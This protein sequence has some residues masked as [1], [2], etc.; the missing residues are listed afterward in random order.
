[1]EEYRHYLL[2]HNLTLQIYWG[3]IHDLLDCTLQLDKTFLSLINPLNE[4]LHSPIT[5]EWNWNPQSLSPS[6]HTLEV[7]V[8][9]N[10]G[11]VKRSWNERL[12]FDL[13]TVSYIQIPKQMEEN[14]K[15]LQFKQ[16]LRCVYGQVLVLILFL[17]F[18]YQSNKNSKERPYQWTRLRL[19]YS[20]GLLHLYVLGMLSLFC[21]I[22][23]CG[24]IQSEVFIAFQWGSF[25]WKDSGGWEYAHWRD[26]T[27]WAWY[28]CLLCI[29]PMFAYCMCHVKRPAFKTTYK[30]ILFRL[31]EWISSCIPVVT[32]C[33]L[34]ILL[35]LNVPLNVFL[36]SF[37]FTWLPLIIVVF[38]FKMCDQ[39]EFVPLIPDD[40]LI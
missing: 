2:Q 11:E 37:N 29:L 32:I 6:I 38:S 21:G 22:Y 8:V 34:W 7:T 20:Y 3:S 35:F 15:E 27:F 28:E 16:P 4:T 39:H 24:S 10:H 17:W 18:W 5:L 14:V 12:L 19:L 23:L 31:I 1:M 13:S 36:L 26:L 40:K 30:L 9:Y 33:G 25:T